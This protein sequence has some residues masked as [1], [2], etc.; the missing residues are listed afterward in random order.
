MP[1][2]RQPGRH[3]VEPESQMPGLRARMTL[4]A[5]QQACRKGLVLVLTVAVGSMALGTDCVVGQNEDS[6][7]RHM[8]MLPQPPLCAR[9]PCLWASMSLSSQWGGHVWCG[10]RV[11]S[12]M[13]WPCMTRG[14]REVVYDV[15][16][17]VVPDGGLPEAWW[18][19]VFRLLGFS[20]PG[21]QTPLGIPTRLGSGEVPAARGQL[22]SV[23]RVTAA[24]ADF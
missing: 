5:S 24:G 14:P 3:A 9:P 16:I 12:Y 20:A 18:S 17:F 10:K 2:V 21:A 1:E 8:H 11:W 4:K 15:R 7:K 22:D 6:G 23:I 19:Q 13:T